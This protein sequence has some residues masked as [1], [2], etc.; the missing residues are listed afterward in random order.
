MIVADQSV[1][2]YEFALVLRCVVSCFLLDPQIA[3]IA[4]NKQATTSKWK[5]ETQNKKEPEK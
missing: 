2:G 1:E 4:N 3:P 5:Q